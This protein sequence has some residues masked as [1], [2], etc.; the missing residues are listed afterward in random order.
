MKNNRLPDNA[1]KLNKACITIIE[2][3]IVNPG[4]TPV[5]PFNK[6]T[7]ALVTDIKTIDLKTFTTSVNPVCLITLLKEP[8][9]KKLSA[10]TTKTNGSSKKN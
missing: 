10:D 5:S 2:I 4:T 7:K 3:G 9:T 6:I 8:T 1:T